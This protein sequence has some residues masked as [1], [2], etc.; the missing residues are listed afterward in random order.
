MQLRMTL[1]K[2][3][4]GPPLLAH[5]SH[6]EAHMFERC[7]IEGMN[8]ETNHFDIYEPRFAPPFIRDSTLEMVRQL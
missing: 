7:W 4:C 3:R 8:I 5:Y 6:F 2:R 1:S